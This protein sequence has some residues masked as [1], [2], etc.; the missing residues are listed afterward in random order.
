MMFCIWARKR[1]AK[2]DWRDA[3]ESVVHHDTNNNGEL[4]DWS[5]GRA[6]KLCES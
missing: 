4:T 1:K 2:T 5:G 6:Q 3:N